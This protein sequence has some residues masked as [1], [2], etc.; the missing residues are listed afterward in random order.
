MGTSEKKRTSATIF[1][2]A[3]SISLM[4]AGVLYSYWHAAPRAVQTSIRVV[5]SSTMKPVARAQVSLTTEEGSTIVGLTDENGLSLLTGITSRTP[6][7]TARL[8][9]TADGY[10]AYALITRLGSTVDEIPLRQS[11]SSANSQ[12]QAFTVTSNAVSGDG[13][14]WGQLYE[15][16]S[17]PAPTGYR[18]VHAEFRLVGDRQCGAWAEC[19]EVEQND[20]KVCW[21]FRLQG[22][23]ERP[24]ADGRA[25]SRAEL[26][27]TI[28]KLGLSGTETTVAAQPVCHLYGQANQGSGAW[29]RDDVC[30]IPNIN[31]LDHD[32]RQNDFR[33]CG[34]GATSPTT[35][36]EIPPGLELRVTGGHYWSVANPRIDGENFFLHTYCGPE[37]FPGPGCN[38]DVEVIAHY[39]SAPTSK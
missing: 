12:I 6:R 23:G 31:Y 15:L 38:V 14:S 3:I 29:N 7:S 22:H 1:S 32:Y 24:G 26:T 39:R 28:D 18:V 10:D 13:A 11:R 37:P 35:T 5:D 21:Q 20:S 16:C 27:V 4:L 25:Q 30:T 2:V 19:R 34:G 9:I 33:C 36:A 8:M 17:N